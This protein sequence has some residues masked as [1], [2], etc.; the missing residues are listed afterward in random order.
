MLYNPGEDN[1][2][3]LVEYVVT[4]ALVAFAVIIIILLLAP[5]VG[6]IFSNIKQRR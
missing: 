6:N 5:T 1:N 4:L 3:G 2:Q